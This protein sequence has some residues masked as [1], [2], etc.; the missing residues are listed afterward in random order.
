MNRRELL[1]LFSMTGTL[2]ASPPIDSNLDTERITAAADR[3]G[4]LDDATAEGYAKLNGYLWQVF[5]LA[6]SK[7][8]VLPLVREQLTVLSDGLSR[9]RGG[10]RR[11]MWRR[12]VS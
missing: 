8:K 7:R 3:P 5:R 6:A 2:L 11:L 4:P 1:R 12:G 10:V 9:S